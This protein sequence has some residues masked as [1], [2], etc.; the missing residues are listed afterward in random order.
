[1]GQVT[2]RWGKFKVKLPVELLLCVLF[3]TFLMLHN[4]NA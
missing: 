1:M 2:V 3:R 4:V